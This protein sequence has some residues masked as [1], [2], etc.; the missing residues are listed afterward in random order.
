VGG[1]VDETESRMTRTI[2]VLDDESIE[3]KWDHVTTFPNARVGFS[4]CAVGTKIYVFAGDARH[5][6]D[7]DMYHSLST[8]DAFDIVTK[9]WDSSELEEADRTMPLLDNW[10]QAVA[11]DLHT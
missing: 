11:V 2:E 3:H 8:W 5:T 1:N 4:T 7:Q 6:D 10:G 9:S